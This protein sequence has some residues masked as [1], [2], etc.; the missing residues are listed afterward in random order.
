VR[1]CGSRRPAIKYIIII[2]SMSMFVTLY[3][4]Q[5]IEIMKIELQY[6]KLSDTEQRLV[7]DKDQLL[8]E[9][10]KYRSMDAIREYARR[11][12]LKPVLPEDFGVVALDENIAQ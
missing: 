2:L 11:K 3:V 6:Q 5:N 9:I 10:E 8:Y 12:G 1:R 7:R 4:W